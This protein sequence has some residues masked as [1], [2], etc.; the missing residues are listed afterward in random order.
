MSVSVNTRVVV[1]AQPGPA[2]T[3]PDRA[4]E[5]A[6][7]A[8]RM[9]TMGAARVLDL[10]T[11]YQVMSVSAEAIGKAFG[12]PMDP[13]HPD[14]HLPDVPPLVVLRCSRHPGPG[15]WMVAGT[16]TPLPD[17][18]GGGV[19]R[20]GELDQAGLDLAELVVLALGHERGEH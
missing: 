7:T 1:P 19:L 17:D 15:H 16:A 6:A 2:D 10:L 13:P 4:G 12:D 20:L 8:R 3:D 18:D 9:G 5:L 14:G 11:G